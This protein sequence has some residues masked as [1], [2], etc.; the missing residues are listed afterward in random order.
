[1][2]GSL[3]QVSPHARSALCVPKVVK[4]SVCGKAENY[5]VAILYM[6]LYEPVGL[7]GLAMGLARSGMEAIVYILPNPVQSTLCLV[8]QRDANGQAPALERGEPH[9]YA[10]VHFSLAVVFFFSTHTIEP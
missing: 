5:L 7:I 8:V 3:S 9:K 1:L 2:D 10:M 6:P 4:V